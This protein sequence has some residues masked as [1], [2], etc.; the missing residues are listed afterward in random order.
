MKTYFLRQ[1][2]SV[3]YLLIVITS[4][5]QAQAPEPFVCDMQG[6]LSHNAS[7][8]GL[9]IDTVDFSAGTIAPLFPSY[10]GFEANNIAYNPNDDFLY[11]VSNTNVTINGISISRSDVV[12]IG[13]NGDVQNLG[14]P[15]IPANTG[16]N[17][18]TFL[19]D[20]RLVLFAN[21]TFYVIDLVSFT[22][23]SMAPSASL[24]ITDFAVN[25]VDGLLYTCLLYTSPSPRDKRQSRMPSSA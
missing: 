11:V 9:Q 13:S 12:R 14:N 16:Y 4:Q 17:A 8:V 22:V 2:V 20:G 15:G 7:G 10:P 6:F 19:P 18:A 23:V 25:P 1:C 24:D 21:D 3:F 5:V